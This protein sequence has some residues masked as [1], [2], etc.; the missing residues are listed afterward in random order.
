MFSR[1]SRYRRL[2]DE[3]T[4]DERGRSLPSKSLRLLPEVSGQFLH[5]IEEVDRLDHLAYRYYRQPRKWWHICD[6]NPQFLSPQGLLGKE[7]IVTYR[8]PLDWDNAEGPPPW[9]ALLR[10]LSDT[11]GVLDVHVEE[12]WELIPGFLQVD[13]DQV[14]IDVDYFTRAVVVEYNETSVTALELADIMAESGFDVGQ[15]QHEGRIGKQ[16][17]IPPDVT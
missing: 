6:A 10:A 16:I 8:F 4:V 12:S 17:V 11:V 3:V 5:T 15:P 13:G 2:P 7:P 9:A 1:I 14:R